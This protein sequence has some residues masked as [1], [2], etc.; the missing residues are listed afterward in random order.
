MV[1]DYYD[2]YLKAEDLQGK[3][4]NVKVSGV[5]I[6]PHY[7]K[8]LKQDDPCIVLS[9]EGKYRKLILNRGQ[10]DDITRALDEA[11]EKKWIGAELS[12]S[13]VKS[14]GGNLTTI[15]VW[16]KT[17]GNAAGLF[18]LGTPAATRP[19]AKNVPV[20]VGQ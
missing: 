11:D 14:Y 5:K 2:L 20:E 9:F 12:L 10:A 1:Y 3:T 13:P 19:A 17:L 8:K 15:K 18:G 6:E 7:N 16:S 4:V